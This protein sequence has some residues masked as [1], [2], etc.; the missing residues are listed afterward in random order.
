M[1]AGVAVG[2]AVGALAVV[3]IERGA[4]PAGAQGGSAELEAA[5]NRSIRAIKQGVVAYNLLGKYVAE[6]DQ[7]VSVKSPEN[8]RQDRGVGGGLPTDVYADDSVTEPKLSPELRAKI[9]AS[10]APGPAGPAGAPGPTGP[11]GPTASARAW[12]TSPK[13][14]DQLLLINIPIQ[15]D[16]PTNTTGPIEM[17]F[18]GTLMANAILNFT[19]TN[20]ADAEAECRLWS[21]R[22]GSLL[23]SPLGAF[24]VEFTIEDGETL[25]VS[26]VGSLGRPAGTHD[27]FVRCTTNDNNVQFEAGQ[28]NAWAA[29]T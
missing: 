12:N 17:P 9:N 4:E 26:L 23:V 25:P 3:G 18:D 21:R 7:L 28:V 14:L 27:V 5:N 11:P 13:T 15:L 22:V 29:A 10:G 8:V 6:K 1:L 2:L 16:Q 24:A 19:K 20:L